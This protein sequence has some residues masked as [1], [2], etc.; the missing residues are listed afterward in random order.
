MPHL[1]LQAGLFSAV[2]S[3]FVIDVHSNLQPDPNEQSAA[4]LRAILLTLNQSAIPG[5]TPTVP[6]V[7]AGPASETVTTTCLMYASLLISL[8]AAFIAMLGKQWL[9]R[10]LQNSG[11]SMI[12]RCGDR[13]R[14]FDGLE[15]WPL[16][17]FIESL[18]V[19]LQAALLLL[20]CGLCRHMWS[21][22]T[23]VAYTLVCLTG[24][25]VAFFI[26]IVIA[27]MSSYA[28]PF[29]TP[30]STALR[31]PWKKVRRRAVSSGDHFRRTLSRMI[32][33]LK[34][35]IWPPLRRPLLPIAIPLRNPQAQESEPWLESKDLAIIRR[36]NADDAQCVSWILGNITDPEALDAAVRL[37]GTVRWFDDGINVYPPYDLIVSTFEACFDP[38]GKLFPGSGDRAYYSGRAM[39][40][41]NTLAMC[42]SEELASRFPLPSTKFEGPGLNPDLENLL[43]INFGS[44]AEDFRL[45]LL[46]ATDP[47]HTPSHTQWISDVLLSRSWATTPGAH[48]NYERVLDWIPDA[49]GTK[50]ATPLNVTLNRLLSWCVFLGSPPAEEVLKAQNKSYD[51]SLFCFSSDSHRPQLAIAWSKS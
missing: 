20:A 33:T 2:S 11:G 1:L 44:W 18:P 10:Y 40:W 24:L 47:E 23:P 4:L 30:A 45:S 14:K 25:G 17:F 46:L 26:A 34:Q 38:V 13:Q 36:T 32:R 7:Q 9:N 27:G 31:D 15:K 37:A 16:H 43:Y 28:C 39:M 21:I 51:I 12:E 49:P 48:L 29:Q 8:L 35:R 6:P 3:A 19:M 22:N 42:E 5:E 41:I 50:V